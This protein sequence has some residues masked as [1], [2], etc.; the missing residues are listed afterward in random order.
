MSSDDD[1]ETD[2]ID[3]EYEPP[4][5]IKAA[6]IIALFSPFM[7]ALLYLIFRR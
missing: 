2:F 7:A 4:F 1:A 6:L 5:L 3:E